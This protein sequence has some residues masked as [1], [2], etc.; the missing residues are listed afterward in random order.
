MSATGLKCPACGS[1][2]L[3]GD[4]QCPNCGGDLADLDASAST[5]LGTYLQTHTLKE[6]R[7]S[8]LVVLDE[9]DTLEKAVKMMAGASTGAAMVKAADGTWGIFSERDIL[10]KIDPTTA[11]LTQHKLAEFVTRDP[12]KLRPEDSVAIALNKMSIGGYRHIPLFD[13]SGPVGMIS[14]RDILAT[15]VDAMA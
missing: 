5:P 4:D 1:D 8:K 7:Q 11:D 12:V 13:K 10:T 6:M 14:V 2:Y 9:S 15:L 3:S